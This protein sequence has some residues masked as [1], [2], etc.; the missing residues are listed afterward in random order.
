MNR[1]TLLRHK[2]DGHEFLCIVDPQSTVKA[3]EV[4][5]VLIDCSCLCGHEGDFEIVFHGNT[6]EYKSRCL[7]NSKPILDDRRTTQ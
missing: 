6:T 3:W 7:E 4:G 2:T 1:A 5:V